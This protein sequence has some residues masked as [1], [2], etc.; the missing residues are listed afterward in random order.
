MLR[1]VGSSRNSFHFPYAVF[2]IRAHLYVGAAHIIPLR[3]RCV[4]AALSIRGMLVQ[5]GPERSVDLR[6]VKALP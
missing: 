4:S 6:G 2:C 1:R 5:R 3:F